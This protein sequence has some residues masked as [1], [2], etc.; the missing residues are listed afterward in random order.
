MAHQ[1]AVRKVQYLNSGVKRTALK[2][3]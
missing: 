2:Q 1:V 3:H